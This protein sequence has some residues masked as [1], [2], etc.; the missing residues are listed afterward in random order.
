M[1][2][3]EK[4]YSWNSFKDYQ[5]DFIK[6]KKEYYEEQDKNKKEELKKKIFEMINCAPKVNMRLKI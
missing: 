1:D 4:K 3:I 2:E 6:V 5:K